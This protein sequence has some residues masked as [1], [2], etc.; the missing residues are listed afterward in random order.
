[1]K[2]ILLFLLLLYSSFSYSQETLSQDEIYFD[3]GLAYHSQTETLLNATV[4]FKGKKGKGVLETFEEGKLTRKKYYYSKEGNPY[5]Y[6]EFYY[7]STDKLLQRIRNYEGKNR[8]AIYTYDDNGKVKSYDL[9]ENS[10]HSQH[11]EY[12]NGKKHGIWFCLEK[13]GNLCERV[14]ENGKKI[15]NC[16]T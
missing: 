11:E 2:R 13:D 4:D 9:Y 7:N 12:L 1:M 16:S 3:F 5:I 6:E 15:K 14:F 10:V 8:Y